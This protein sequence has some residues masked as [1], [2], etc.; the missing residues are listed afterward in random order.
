VR[1][2]YKEKFRRQVRVESK[3]F[4]TPWPGL[5]EFK[6]RNKGFLGIYFYFKKEV[7]V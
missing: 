4:D 5:V 1:V 3:R 7:H 6:K 2:D